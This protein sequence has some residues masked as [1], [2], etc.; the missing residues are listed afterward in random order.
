MGSREVEATGRARAWLALALVPG[1]RPAQARRLVERVGSPQAARAL[2][3]AAVVA[4]GIDAAGW[5]EA[6]ARADRELARLARLGA[7]LRAWDEPAYPAPLRAIADPPLVLAVLGVLD[8]A[9]GNDAGAVAVVGARR[10][11]S[12]GK[13][14]AED[15]ACGLA[16]AGLTVVSGLA[17]GIDAAAHRGALAAGGRTV[18]V[19]A[20]G[21]DQVY[22]PWHAELSRRVVAGGALVTEFPCGTAPLPYHFPRRNRLISGLSLGTVVV[23]AAPG[24]GSLI[25]ARY[26]LEQG[27]EVFAVPGPIGVALHAGA[28]RLIQEGAKL[29]RGVEDVL[30]EIAP[31]LRARAMASRM[32]TPALS[33]VEARVLDA[34]RPDDAHVDEVIRRTAL[35]PGVALETLLALELRGVVEQQPGMRFRARAA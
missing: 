22:P 6:D 1:L 29:V 2:S 10:A 17:T 34:V 18:A 26:A 8:G 12:Y 5:A 24:S 20:T 33:T 27:R 9:L 31:Q 25:T 7:S 14:V 16:A 35:A 11:S 13:R 21:L 23:E 3:P 28:N 19:L 32:R 15:L 4:T 30:D